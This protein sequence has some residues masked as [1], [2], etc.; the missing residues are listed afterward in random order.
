MKQA[1][2][3]VSKEPVTV[4]DIQTIDAEDS[5]YKKVVEAF[6]TFGARVLPIITLDSKPVCM[7]TTEPMQI[8]TAL[9]REIN[10]KKG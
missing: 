8:A 3:Q 5:E 9:E 10:N 4:V 7:G 6:N 2:E 1:A